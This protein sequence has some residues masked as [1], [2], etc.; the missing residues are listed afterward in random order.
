[1]KTALTTALIATV[2][3]VGG[4]AAFADSGGATSNPAPVR[5]APAGWSADRIVKPGQFGWQ[6]RCPVN[7]PG[8]HAQR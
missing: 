7:N 6:K 1:M 2:V 8:Y 5:G 4:A 3:A